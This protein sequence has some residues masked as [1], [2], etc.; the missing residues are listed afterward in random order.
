VDQGVV[1]EKARERRRRFYRLTPIGQ[2]VLARQRQT[3]D[4]FVDAVRMVT[5]GEHA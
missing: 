4:E 2:D 3:R 5:R 1:V